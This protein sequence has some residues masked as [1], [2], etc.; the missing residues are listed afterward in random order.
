MPPNPLSSLSALD[1]P[2]ILFVGAGLSRRYLGLDPWRALLKRFADFTNQPVEYYLSSADG[3]YPRAGTLIAEAF[4]E[5]WWT[6]PQ[7][8]QS[9][10]RYAKLAEAGRELP[11]KIEIASYASQASLTNDPKLVKELEVLGSAQVDTVITTNYDGLSETLYP[12]FQVFTGQRSLLFAPIHGVAEIY[13]I[14]GSAA[15]PESLVLTED[16]YNRFRK[17]SPYLTAKLATLLVER[18]VMFLGYSLGDA[19]IKDILSEFVGCLDSS[20]VQR[21]GQRLFFVEFQSGADLSSSEDYFSL[22]EGRHHLPLTRIQASDFLPIYEALNSYRRRLPA[23]VLRLLKERV[24]EL[25][26]STDPAGSLAAIDIDSDTDTRNIDVVFGVGVRSARGYAPITREDLALD[27][28]ADEMSFDAR[29][30]L[31]LTIPAQYRK[32]IWIPVWRYLKRLTPELDFSAIEDMAEA[33]DALVQ[34]DPSDYAEGNPYSNSKNRQRANAYPSLTDL[35]EG[36]ELSK[37][38]YFLFLRDTEL[39]Y[40]EVDLLGELLSKHKDPVLLK[41]ADSRKSLWIKAV[42]LYDR[43]KYGLAPS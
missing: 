22:H 3:D 21:F 30:V 8:E 26:E 41:P 5:V 23:R 6:N 20:Q 17:E 9:R 18:P 1:G 4:H 28:L 7:F 40:S 15:E 25:V 24:Y 38:L 12:D 13:K 34:R 29:S 32:G 39:V 2:P 16:D 10:D 37:A 42:C 33:V 14:H 35:F 31:N 36:E 11:L 27:V 43:L 19:Y